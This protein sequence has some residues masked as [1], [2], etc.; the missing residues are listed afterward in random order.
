MKT[1]NTKCLTT[2]YCQRMRIISF[3]AICHNESLKKASG[4]ALLD[5]ISQGNIAIARSY[6][7]EERLTVLSQQADAEKDF[8]LS[9]I[10]SI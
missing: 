6:Y 9:D 10:V 5:G 3:E 8:D 2:S 7:L 1:S 4:Q